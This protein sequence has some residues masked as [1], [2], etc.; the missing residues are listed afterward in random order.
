MTY[1]EQ[2]QESEIDVEF[3][4]VDTE[5]DRRVERSLENMRAVLLDAALIG[6]EA[7]EVPDEHFEIALA[8]M[9]IADAM[10]TVRNAVTILERRIKHYRKRMRRLCHG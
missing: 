2:W 1:G 5:L 9:P 10:E 3:T 7:S 8:A 6:K 4:A